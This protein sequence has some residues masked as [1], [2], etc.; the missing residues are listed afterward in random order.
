M[1]YKIYKRIR[2]YLKIHIYVRIFIGII[3]GII[4]IFPLVLPF[5]GSFPVGIILL[6]FALLIILPWNKIRHIIKL[7]KWMIFLMKNFHKKTI[8]RHKMRDF[9]SHIKQILN[10]KHDR[11]MQRL[12]RLEALRKQKK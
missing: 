10:D 2:N 1:E 5:P 6:V 8:V 9:S 4:A 12:A 11:R 3:I 7:R